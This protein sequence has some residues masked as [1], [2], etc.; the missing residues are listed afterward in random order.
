MS[1][2]ECRSAYKIYTNLYQRDYNIQANLWYYALRLL[3][4]TE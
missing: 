4:E 1:Q 3:Y 2:K